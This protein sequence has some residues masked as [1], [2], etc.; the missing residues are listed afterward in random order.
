M[1]EKIIRLANWL[2]LRV[3]DMTVGQRV[4][5]QVDGGSALHGYINAVYHRSV[6]FLPDE[7]R[8]MALPIDDIEDG[9]IELRIEAPA[10]T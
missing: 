6:L 3:E 5:V 8:E 7:E 10:K 2:P 4:K 9:T 1:S